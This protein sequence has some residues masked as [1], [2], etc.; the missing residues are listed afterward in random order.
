MLTPV[1]SIP[2]PSSRTCLHSSLQVE[3]QFPIKQCQLQCLIQRR[4]YETD[5]SYHQRLRSYHGL[6]HFFRYVHTRCLRG[7]VADALEL[8][9]DKIGV[10]TEED[11]HSVCTV[12]R[13]QYFGTIP[14]IRYHINCIVYSIDS[15]LGLSE[16][17]AKQLIYIFNLYSNSRTVSHCPNTAS[18]THGP[19]L[20]FEKGASR[21]AHCFYAKSDYV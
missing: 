13:L 15:I 16:N 8:F 21:C 3:S 10:C 1:L 18:H 11:L 5:A 9:L 7:A 6:N 12:G 17:G 4:S 20:F 2:V 19:W 14:Y